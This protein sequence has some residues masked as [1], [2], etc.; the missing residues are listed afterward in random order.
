MNGKLTAP[1]IEANA[2]TGTNNALVIF[3]FDDIG[4]WWSLNKDYIVMKLKGRQYD[5]IKLVISSFGGDLIEALVI[6]DLLKAYPAPVTAYLTGICASAA[7]IVSDAADTIIMSRQ[8]LYMIHKAGIYTQGNAEDLRKAADLLDTSDAIIADIYRRRTGM[9]VDDIM[10]LM[11]QETWMGPDEAMTLGF[12]DEVAD[13]L[14]IDFEVEAASQSQFLNQSIIFDSAPSVYKQ[15]VTNC[16]SNNYKQ[17][18]PADAGRYRIQNNFSMNQIFAKFISALVAAGI[19]TQ[20]NQEKATKV[21]GEI[22]LPDTISN[23]VKEEIGKMQPAA[24]VSLTA[25]VEALSDEDKA[26]LGKLLNIAPVADDTAEPQESETDKRIKA[27]T[28]EIADLKAGGKGTKR[29]GNGG[30]GLENNDEDG[31]PSFADSEAKKM[32]LKAFEAGT[33]DAKTYKE[34]TGETAPRKKAEAA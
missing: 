29:E 15:A 3:A 26:K 17:L 21:V 30:S 33:I 14:G 12:V 11:S 9:E 6:R 28:A 18:L 23:I 24:P 1:L 22:D 16:I 4:W 8:C 32:Y 7:T 10:A 25:Q 5:E 20:E 34:L 19:I 27:L 2:G 13:D 31:K